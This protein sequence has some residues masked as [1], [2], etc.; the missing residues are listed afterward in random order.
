MNESDLLSH[1]EKLYFHELN[2]KEQI[3][4]RLSIPLAVIVATFGFYAVILAA[5]PSSLTVGTKIW[6]WLT[7]SLSLILLLAAIVFFIDCLLGRMDKAI[8]TP[9]ATVAYREELL[10]YYSD[11]EDPEDS[12]SKHLKKTFLNYYSECAT[13]TIINNDRKSSSFYY[14]AIFLIAAS[15]FAI[16]SYTL[17]TFPKL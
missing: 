8:P 16:V 14:C 6:F 1:A 10:N 12:T 5:N 3:F 13:L 11:T 4:S 7:F 17:V 15:F 9:D 2:R